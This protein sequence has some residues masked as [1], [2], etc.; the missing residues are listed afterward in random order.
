MK[1]LILSERQKPR[2]LQAMKDILAEHSA[3]CA[4]GSSCRIMVRLKA[5]IADL[6]AQVRRQGAK[7][8][9]AGE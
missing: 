9:S 7:G 3:E 4:H 6:E 5:D 2:I 8:R 1:N